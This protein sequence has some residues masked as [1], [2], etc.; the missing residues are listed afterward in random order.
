M[1]IPYAI[2]N[3]Y[4]LYKRHQANEKGA[5]AFKQLSDSLS[6]GYRQP[7]VHAPAMGD[8]TDIIRRAEAV[9]TARGGKAGFEYLLGQTDP[10]AL[11]SL[12]Q[13]RTQN[14]LRGLQVQQG[15]Q[16][17][18]AHTQLIE[19]VG[20]GDI[21]NI[22]PKYTAALSALTPQQAG[23][24]VLTAAR[25]GGGAAETS[26]QKN[27]KFRQS[28]SKDE[29]PVFDSMF[30]SQQL[31][32]TGGGGRDVISPTGKRETLVTPQAFGQNE[33]LSD[34]EKQDISR[35]YAE[36]VALPQMQSTA[37]TTIAL[38]DQAL[39]HP[40]FDSAYGL[41]QIIP[42]IP[43]S[44]RADFETFMNQGK[45]KV[46]TEAYE[47]LKGGGSITEI[48]VLKG[49]QAIAR[50]GDPKQ[51][52][53]SARQAWRDLQDVVRSGFE[54]RKQQAAQSYGVTGP[55][56]DP[57]QSPPTQGASRFKVLERK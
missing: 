6:A 45:G 32:D 33:G 13:Q 55:R 47:N 34:V 21:P 50:I 12:Q 29:K 28:L 10:G 36:Q 5:D 1:P 9:K 19:D 24:R 2:N 11:A 7:S 46:F 30:R 42:A 4:G 31:I 3:L 40:G 17:H 22:D 16:R 20:E 41:S 15:Q 23:S 27:Y 38:A 56:T 18:L 35:R 37:N 25:V 43:G 26:Q 39:K 52:P 53:A 49:E 48:E 51:S 54:R 14:A 44:A 8:P 57:L